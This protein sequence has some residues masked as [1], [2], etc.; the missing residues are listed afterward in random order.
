MKK[1]LI[2]IAAVAASFAAQATVYRAG[3]KGGYINSYNNGTLPAAAFSYLD[4]VFLGPAAATSRS[5]DV[6]S[7][8]Y[9]PFWANNRSWSFKGEMY[10]DGGTYWF[11]ERM[12]DMAYVSVD[13]VQV[14]SDATW[15]NFANASVSPAAGWHA[16]D[17][18]FGNGTGGAG[19]LMDNLLPMI[20]LN[21]VDL[22]TFGLP[23]IATFGNI[24][25]PPT[26]YYLLIRL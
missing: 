23:T 22:P 16:V 19:Y 12:D 3:L 26:I 6:S 5:S 15:N 7:T 2:G 11:G 8:S 10:F 9:P 4:D 18:R 24:L 1:T 21:N 14:L 13:G 17:F 25:T 20:R